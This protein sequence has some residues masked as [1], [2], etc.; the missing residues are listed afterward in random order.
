MLRAERRLTQHDVAERLGVSQAQ[1]WK[2][3][4]AI[5]EPSDDDKRRLARVFRVHVDALTS[6]EAMTA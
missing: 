1:Y 6:T 5:V 4:T 3:E 2:F